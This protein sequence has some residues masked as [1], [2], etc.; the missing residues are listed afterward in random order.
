[1][2]YVTMKKLRRVKSTQ[3]AIR[4]NEE[5]HHAVLQRQPLLWGE[6]VSLNSVWHYDGTTVDA[7]VIVHGC[8]V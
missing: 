3:H 7:C 5:T 2:P 6:I 4:D 1:M 8:V